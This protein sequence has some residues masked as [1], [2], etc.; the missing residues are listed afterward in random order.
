MEVAYY[1]ARAK[2]RI[3]VSAVGIVILGGG[4][5]YFYHSALPAKIT[6][7]ESSAVKVVAQKIVNNVA[8]PLPLVATGTMPSAASGGKYTLTRAGVVAQ[9][10]L[11]RQKNGSLPAL[12][13]N[14]Q[15]DTIATLRLKDMFAKQYFA[16][17]S[18]ASSSALTVASSVGYRYVALGENLALGDFFGDQGVVTAWMNSPGHR[19]NILSTHY[20]QIGVAVAEG[21]FNGQEDWI[22]VQVFGKPASECPPVNASLKST[23]DYTQAQLAPAFD[24]LQAEK[25]NLQAMQQSGDTSYNQT[26]SAYNAF[27]AQYNAAINQQKQNI[28]QY[29]AQVNAYNLCIK[30]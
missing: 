8:N 4:L 26:V 22:A 30:N 6:V 10:N 12:M 28:A 11:Q 24:N 20:T 23:I 21:F 3:A 16:H 2:K 19:A 13:E 14:D 9:T 29:N 27:V 7:L 15:L 1:R 25:A 17:V 18:P 5:W